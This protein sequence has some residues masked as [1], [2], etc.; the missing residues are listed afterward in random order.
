MFSG[1]F[2]VCRFTVN[3]QWNA[4]IRRNLGQQDVAANPSGASCGGRERLSFFDGGNGKCKF[5]N[6][7]NISHAPAFKI[8]MESDEIRCFVFADF[9][10]HGC[11]CGVQNL[12]TERMRLR[13]ELKWGVAVRT[14]VIHGGGIRRR[15]R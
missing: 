10:Q 12:A 6:E 2:A 11:V 1:E 5:R 8:V 3:D 7:K 4:R 13:F 15:A 9:L 14:N